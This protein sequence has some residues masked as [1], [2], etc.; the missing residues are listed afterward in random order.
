MTGGS[1]NADRE[2]GA[3]IARVVCTEKVILLSREVSN[4]DRSL[5][6]SGATGLIPDPG[7]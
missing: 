5:P 2:R 4:A 7:G 3:P 6:T 1:Q